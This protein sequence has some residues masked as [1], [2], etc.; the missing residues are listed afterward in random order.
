VKNGQRLVAKRRIA[1]LY[2][3]GGLQMDFTNEVT[4]SLLLNGLQRLVRQSEL[5]EENQA[6]L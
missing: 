6:F 3:N 4:Q 5:S 2:K 1:A